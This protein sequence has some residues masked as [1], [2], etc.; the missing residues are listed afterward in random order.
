MF[1]FS[2][3][4]L[5]DILKECKEIFHHYPN[6]TQIHFW[7]IRCDGSHNGMRLQEKSISIVTLGTYYCCPHSFRNI[8]CLFISRG[9]ITISYVFIVWSKPEEKS[10]HITEIQMQ[11]N[12]DFQLK[13]CNRTQTHQTHIVLT[14]MAW[15]RTLTF[16]S[17]Y[18]KRRHR[19]L[20]ILK[21]MF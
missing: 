13:S 12:F 21:Q 18:M 3:I 10:L 5:V 1:G 7:N 9:K 14:C 19:P 20:S 15:I 2:S 4:F 8:K 17:S 16:S 6:L 11:I